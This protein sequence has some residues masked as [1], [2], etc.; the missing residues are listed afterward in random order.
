MATT[1]VSTW[2]LLQAS[3]TGVELIWLS[4]VNG[5]TWCLLTSLNATLWRERELGMAGFFSDFVRPNGC[6]YIMEEVLDGER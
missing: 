5:Y 2:E 3:L 6:C 1:S 4:H